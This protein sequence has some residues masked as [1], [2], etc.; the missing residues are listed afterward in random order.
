MINF[1]PQI[2]KVLK[3]IHSNVVESF[4]K[5]WETFPILIYEEED[6]TP[7]TITTIGEAM[8]S[9][10]YRIEIYSNE[11]TSALKTK[12]NDEFEVLGLTRVFCQDSNDLDGRRHTT[13]RYE[14]VIDLDNNKIYKK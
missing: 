1:K 7:H 12:I 14:G 4:P 13:M 11:S 3:K 8:T 2:V 5:S 6:N 10:R 9:L